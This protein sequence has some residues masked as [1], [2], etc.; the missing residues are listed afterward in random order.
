MYIVKRT[1]RTIG[2]FLTKT[3]LKSIE[4]MIYLFFKT[5]KINL[6]PTQVK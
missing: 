5:A 3:N 6:N 1:F 2:I 4:F